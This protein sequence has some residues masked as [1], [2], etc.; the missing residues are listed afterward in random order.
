VLSAEKKRPLCRLFYPEN[1]SLPM[2]E[3]ICRYCGKG[4]ENHTEG[5]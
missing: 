3:R 1:D 4:P 5:E 2:A